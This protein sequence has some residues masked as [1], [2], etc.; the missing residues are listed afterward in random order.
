VRPND[1]ASHVRDR[2]GGQAFISM[3]TVSDVLFGGRRATDEADRRPAAAVA[4]ALLARFSVLAI[5]ASI[6]RL[7]AQLK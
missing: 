2:S 3:I 7:H 6:A 4:E 5:N 1:I